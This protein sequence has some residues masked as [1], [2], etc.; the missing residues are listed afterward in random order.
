TPELLIPEEATVRTRVPA[1]CG[2]NSMFVMGRSGISTLERLC[3]HVAPSS[4][5][6]KMPPLV[7]PTNIMRV[8]PSESAIAEIG[9]SSNEGDAGFQFWPLSSVLQSR[10]DPAQRVLTPGR[11]ER[12]I[13]ITV[14]ARW[15]V[16]PCSI[17]R[18]LTSFHPERSQGRPE[19]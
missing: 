7:V 14:K 15:S 11:V 8:L 17:W 9:V 10:V 3:D 1:F 19:R 4:R 12:S 5:L 2:W 18:G 13:A 16:S 6:R